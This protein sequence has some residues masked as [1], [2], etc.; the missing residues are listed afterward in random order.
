MKCRFRTR[1][2]STET[3]I[4]VFN[5]GRAGRVIGES[6]RVTNEALLALLAQNRAFRQIGVETSAALRYTF[7]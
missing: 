5:V 6:H 3:A 7:G 1:R 4:L 2:G